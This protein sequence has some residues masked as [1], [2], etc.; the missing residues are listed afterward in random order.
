[1]L[2]TQNTV[3]SPFSKNKTMTPPKILD[4]QKIDPASDFKY[5]AQP[6]KGQNH[7]GYSIYMNVLDEDTGDEVPFIHQAPPLTL[8]FGISGKDQ[9]GRRAFKFQFNFPTVRY[10]PKKSIWTG[11]EEYV[12]YVK[13]IENIDS[14]NKKHVF[15]NCKLLFGGKQHSE[16]ILD[17]FY[18]HNLYS[19]EKC[20]SGEYS[21]TF[22]AKLIIRAE[23]M[24]TKFFDGV[25]DPASGKH[26]SIEFEEGEEGNATW[27]GLK[28][29]PL[30]KSTGLWFAG[31]IVFASVV[32]LRIF[33]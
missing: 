33:Y 26:P 20:L 16:E 7:D 29:I 6:T 5:N 13:F 15:D 12:N 3:N 11:D 28:V 18:C 1:M 27:K 21:P 25:K 32:W 10:D 2:F 8:P 22:S 14:L 19:G 24:I 31:I 23:K 4:W 30:L 17:E 9:N